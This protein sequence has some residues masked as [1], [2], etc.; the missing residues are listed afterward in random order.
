MMIFGK[1]LGVKYGVKAVCR[2]KRRWPQWPNQTKKNSWSARS[3]ARKGL[4]YLENF[5]L[6]CAR[7]LW[8]AGATGQ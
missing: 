5:K 7:N 4:C 1:L 6:S 2:I 3:T 8:M